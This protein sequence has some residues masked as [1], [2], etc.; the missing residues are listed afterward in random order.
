MLG[1]KVADKPNKEELVKAYHDCTSCLIRQTVEASRLAT[2]DARLQEEILRATLETLATI[3]FDKTPSHMAREVHRLVQSMSCNPD[4]YKEVKHQAN[5]T[6]RAARCAYWDKLPAIAKS[7]EKAALL[8]IAGNAMDIGP[9][10]GQDKLD[11]WSVIDR[12]LSCGIDMNQLQGLVRACRGARQIL[13]LG[14]NA[15]EIVLDRIL[16]EKLPMDRITY[17]VKAKPILNDATMADAEYAGLTEIVEVIDNG[18]DA[19]GTILES[20]SNEFRVRF[21]TSDVVIAKGQANYETLSESGKKG[22]YFV[23]LVKCPVLA[24]DLGCDVGEIIVRNAVPTLLETV[25]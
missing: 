17:V 4:P 15:G 12:V 7:L 14:D 1:F 3:S 23:L 11:I 2:S 6:A 5:V 8:A 21:E 20:C 18:S 25:P 24:R 10:S 22:L 19:P 9:K 13:Y 16:I